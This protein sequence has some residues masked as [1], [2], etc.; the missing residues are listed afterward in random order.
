MENRPIIAQYDIPEVSPVLARY[1]LVSGKEGGRAGEISKSGVQRILMID[2]YENGA[3]KELNFV[4]EIT[5]KYEINSDYK[6]INLKEDQTV[7]LELLQQKAGLKNTIRELT[8]VKGYSSGNGFEKIDQFWFSY[9]Q[10]D[11]RKICVKNGYFNN[12]TGA[13]SIM[14]G[15]LATS[16]TFGIFFSVFFSFIPIIGLIIDFILLLPVIILFGVSFL[17]DKIIMLFAGSNFPIIPFQAVSS[18][19]FIIT[20][21]SWFAWI[22]LLAQNQNIAFTP[23][24]Q[25][26]RDLIWKLN[27]YKQF[28][29]K[30]DMN[31]I[32]FSLDRDLDYQRNNTTFAWLAV[33]SLAKDKHWDNFMEVHGKNLISISP[34]DDI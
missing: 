12:T 32:S 19:L 5:I 8:D 14:S 15:L 23:V 33:F 28:L 24:N 30:V 22:Y 29:K 4:D 3:L 16:M 7:F 17:L 6:K 31:R 11:L 10:Q 9:W 27:G 20:F 21:L 34:K 2:L 26:G 13:I 1:I 25:K 18:F